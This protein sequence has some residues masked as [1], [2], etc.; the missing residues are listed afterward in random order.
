MKRIAIIGAGLSGLVCAQKLHNNNHVNLF[1]KA[2][3]TG[4]RMSTRY[5]PPYQFDH[6]AQ[7]FTVQ[8]PQ[9]FDFL[10][11]QMNQQRI[12]AWN[13][14]FGR[15][16]NAT[17]TQKTP[18]KTRYV[19]S[20]KM[21]LLCK[22][23]ARDLNIKLQT[24]ITGITERKDKTFQ[25]IDDEG[26]MYGPYDHV[27]SS[28]PH[29]QFQE[30]FKDFITKDDS[31]LKNVTMQGCFSL[32][33]GSHDLKLPE[34]D[35]AHVDNS[36]IGWISVNSRKPQRN[37]PACLLIQSTANWAE[38]NMEKNIETVRDELLR[39]LSL[40]VDIKPEKLDHVSIHRWR[41]ASVKTAYGKPYWKA[42]N[43]NLFAI[44]DWCLGSKVEMAFLSAHAFLQDFMSG[45]IQ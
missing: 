20:E 14:I 5:A 41:Y 6:G 22:D 44:G 39:Q 35:G 9:F 2:R 8:S 34:F 38:E 15:I 37:T 33:I 12:R 45:D 30:L 27:I 21:N 7:Y 25:L 17:F 42:D 18:D 13:G 24:R 40:F 26:Q 31:K 3:G 4:G 43:R 16:E 36:A 19:P 23:L 28:M 29:P 11:E 32:M 10:N 1:E